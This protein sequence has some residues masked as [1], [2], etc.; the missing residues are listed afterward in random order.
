MLKNKIRIL[1]IIDTI[2]SDKAGTEG[3]LIKLIKALPTDIYQCYLA[4]FNKSQWLHE[5]DIGI[6]LNIL[7]SSSIRSYKFYVGIIRLIKYIRKNRIDIVQT[8]FPTSITAGVIAARLTGIRRV[9]SCRRDMGFWY[10]PILIS[11]LR[12]SNLLADCF[13]VNSS[14][15]KKLIADVEKI[16]PQKIL[17]IY[18][19]IDPPNKIQGDAIIKLRSEIGITQN[20][21]VIGTVANLNRKVKRVDLFIRAAALI[22]KQCENALFV[23]VG[24]GHLANELKELAEELDVSDDIIFTGLRRDVLDVI[25]LFD[26]GVN[27][28]DS[29]GFSNALLEYMICGVPVVATA[30]GGNSEVVTNGRNGYLVPAWSHVKLANSII[31]IIFSIEKR[32]EMAINAK[33]DALSY[34]FE[35]MIKKYE[36]LYMNLMKRKSGF[37]R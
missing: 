9:I 4:C 22:K 36:T 32:K 23:V 13:L 29:E 14:A 30:C 28:S 18:N 10:T 35:K 26:V 33:E 5:N 34:S 24:D 21:V 19:G 37:Q 11:I 1:F 6:P 3:Q 12:L 16:A 20:H 25:Q 7:G 17:V 15:I 2:A 8:H 31:D 27:C